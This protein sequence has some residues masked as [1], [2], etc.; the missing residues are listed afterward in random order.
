MRTERQ[1]AVTSSAEAA[2]EVTVV[3]PA[4][5][6]EATIR[7][8]VGS[9][10]RQTLHDLEVV[11]VDDASTDGT[12][13]AVEA[14]AAAD[15]RVR[16]IRLDRNGGPSVARNAGIAAARGTW[17]AL[18][19]ADDGFD[20]RRLEGL[21]RAARRDGAA[22]MV[23]DNL[24]FVEDGEPP[25]LMLEGMAGPRRVTLADFLIG[26]V[27]DPRHP[28]VGYGFLKPMMRRAFLDAHG[29]RYD[30]RARFA[31]DFGLYARCLAVGA[32][33]LLLPEGWYDYT[34]HGA[35]LTANHSIED[36]RRLRAMDDDLL[37]RIR[38]TG[39]AEAMMALR[40]HRR[41]IDRRLGWRVFIEDVKRRD[42]AAALATVAA[43]P[44][45]AA[46]ILRQCLIQV[47]VR[48]ARLTR[49]WRTTPGPAPS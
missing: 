24:R 34:V 7:R 35:S 28:R 33:F 45:V 6:A 5:N 3:V 14:I 26:N 46:Y 43:G 17:I 39:D 9:V 48:S 10:L 25:R 49:Q 13:A 16:L 40:R 8:A 31:E 42:A 44:H 2:P 30:E 29:L 27:P 15:P 41:S 19:D 38:A 36:L 12:S 37:H 23:A 20:P 18:L 4:W 32:V 11:V 1:N 47:G 21:L 22:D